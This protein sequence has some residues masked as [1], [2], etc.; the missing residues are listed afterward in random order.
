MPLRRY[1]VEHLMQREAP[2]IHAEDLIELAMQR[3]AA[4]PFGALAVVNDYRRPIGMITDGDLV[5]MVLTEEAQVAPALERLFTES[6]HPAAGARFRQAIGQR[7]S[8]WMS[9]RPVVVSV[10]DSV[11]DAIELFDEYPYQQLMVVEG[12]TFVGFL[13]RG[14]RCPPSPRRITNWRRRAMPSRPS[15]RPA[16]ERARRRPASGPGRPPLRRDAAAAPGT[17]VTFGRAPAGRSALHP[18]EHRSDAPHVAG[19]ATKRHK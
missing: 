3:L 4:S 1:R 19:A 10:G 5:R 12:A 6:D 16:S 14:D 7:V 18:T 9:K 15:G 17:R 11:L 2:T 13:R 8:D